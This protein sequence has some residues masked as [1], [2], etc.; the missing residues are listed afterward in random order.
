M[1]TSAAVR[2]TEGP[3]TIAHLA[4]FG[5]VRHGA[6]GAARFKR[7]GEWQERSY[8]DLAHEVRA[9]ARG[10]I[11]LGIAPG[12]RVCVLA[13]TRW[14]WMLVELAVVTAGAVVVPIYPTNS[15]EE[16]EWVAG[17]SE[18]VAVVCEDPAQLEKIRKVRDRLPHLRTIVLIEGE[19]D[20]AVRIDQLPAAAATE[21]ELEQRMAAVKPGDPLMFIYTS[22][23]TGP[24]KGC[25]LS[26]GNFRALCDMVDDI[27]ITGAG[28][29][30]YLYLPLAH[31]FAQLIEIACLY[32]GGTIAFFGG[33]TKQIV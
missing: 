5:A 7:D 31:V 15:P 33:N 21:A 26:H 20:D 11:D 1:S 25:I 22:G 16:C 4:D 29:V 2:T 6:R 19:D 17:N 14:E 13:S 12:E 8:A 18:A 24:P 32:L 3:A 9:L 30:V 10:L 27:G 28:D 23:T